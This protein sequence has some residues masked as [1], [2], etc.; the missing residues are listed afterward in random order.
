[1]LS[2]VYGQRRLALVIGNASYA[3]NALR[4]PL[5][6][7]SDLSE[8]LENLGFTVTLKKNVNQQQMEEA[9][10]LFATKAHDDD[11][12]LFYYSGHGMQLNGENYLIPVYEKIKSETDCKYKAVNA[13]WILEKLEKAKISIII[14]DACRD[15]PYRGMKSNAVKGM[16]AMTTQSK[17]TFIVYATGPNQ[18]AEDGTG[19][20]SP[21]VIQNVTQEV[22]EST[23]DRQIPWRLSNLTEDFYF[24]GTAGDLK[25]QPQKQVQV[26][27]VPLY[28]TLQVISNETG[29]LYLDEVFICEVKP[30]EK[31]LLKNITTGEHK[32]KIKTNKAEKQNSVFIAADQTSMINFVFTKEAEIAITNSDDNFYSGTVTDIDGNVYKVVK[33]G[34]QYWMAENLKVTHYRNGEPIPHVTDAIQWSKLT[35]GAYC[36]YDNDEALA[37]VYGR[38][39]NWFAV[40]DSRKISPKGWHVPTNV[41]WQTLVDYLGGSGI[42]GSKLKESGNVHWRESANAS[43]NES[44]F[45]AL[46]GGG[47]SYDD[48]AFGNVG[49][50]ASFWSSTEDDS[51]YACNCLLFYDSSD[52]CLYDSNKRYGFSV[53]CVRD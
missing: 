28:G 51:I 7:A 33:I 39:Y 16:A 32:A 36:N 17:G 25:N 22:S 30:N 20:N 46:P 44:G 27:T 45:S 49:Y 50:I 34:S 29:S 53:R 3:D 9:V 52:V 23:G 5:N 37:N 6:D 2:N 42:G 21:L 48:G 12:V 15:N 14:M 13:N 43:S 24:A 10:D 38:L 41:E 40:N 11:I 31:K 47:R 18:T 4:N 26:E 35:N 8:T 1:M 19:R